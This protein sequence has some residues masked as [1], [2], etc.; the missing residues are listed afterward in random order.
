MRRVPKAAARCV[1]VVALGGNDAF[2]ARVAWRWSTGALGRWRVWTLRR[3]S[4]S[5]DLSRAIMSPGV[6]VGTTALLRSFLSEVTR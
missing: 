1:A 4:Y 5:K 6:A 3:R 2:F